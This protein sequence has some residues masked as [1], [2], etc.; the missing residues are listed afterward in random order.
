MENV[1]KFDG[2]EIVEA[3]VGSIA[4]TY[5]RP[6]KELKGFSKVFIKSGEKCTVNIEIDV[7][8]LL[9]YN[10]KLEKILDKGTYKICVGE[11]S[12]KFLEENFEIV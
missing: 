8:Q 2:E 3:Y 9:Y 5:V 1:G 6:D 12:V 11:S 4:S 10:R 7:E